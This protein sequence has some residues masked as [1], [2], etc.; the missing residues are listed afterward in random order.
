MT[1]CVDGGSLVNRKCTDEY[2]RRRHRWVEEPGL[3]RLEEGLVFRYEISR[4]SE[5]KIYVFSRLI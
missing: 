2:R 1:I 4:S 3:V 5:G